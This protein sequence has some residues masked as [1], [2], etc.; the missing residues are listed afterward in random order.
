VLAEVKGMVH[1]L[2][3]AGIEVILDVVYNH[4]CEGDA[5]G[6]HLSW[7]G[8]DN[9]AYY[10]HDGSYPAT[11]ADVT[12]CGNT[13]DFR[14]PQVVRTAMDSVRYWADEVGV[15][16]FRFDLAVTL[17]RGPAGFDR[18]HPFLVALQTD[19]S[20]HG[21]KL[22]AEP[23]DVGPGGWHTGQFPPP[24]AEWNDRFRDA[25]RS[26]WLNDA[27]NAAHGYP[28]LGVR[29]LATRLA[30]SADLFGYSEPPLIRG[31]VAAVNY[32]TAHDGFTMADLVSYEHK[33]NQANGEGN[34]DGSS[35]NRAW[36][37]GFEGPV[38]HDSHGAVIL[39]LRR[40]SIRNL[41]GTLLLAA[42][43]PMITAGD[44]LGRT[45]LG[46]N[47]AFCQDS[48]VSWVDWDVSDWGEDLLDT[49][50]HLLALR[51]DH[52]ALRHDTFFL[53]RPW[54]PGTR[55]DLAW[56]DRDGAPFVDERWHDPH[57]RV[58][59]MLRSAPENDRRTPK[60]GAPESAVLL[61]INGSLDEADV[62]LADDR[63]TT[64]ELV[65]DSAWEHP[66][67]PETL[68]A[69]RDDLLVAA[70]DLTTLEPLSMRVYVSRS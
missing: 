35:D 59:Q 48:P 69:A 47:N 68:T 10:M 53:G 39:P 56:F 61:V 55:P 24:M 15:D 9:P 67:E 57:V 8:L 22:I 11:L 33:H 13:L 70:G 45:Q 62:V 14:R 40:R 54:G 36:N 64:W 66:D 3:Q 6:Q 32:V 31:P 43:T 46:N 27:A 18:L 65:W 26:F 52:P 51:R 25:V 38:A 44:E 34:R 37:H 21:L 2:H 29:E 28:G 49:T 12:G 7:R 30:G 19:P 4:T 50:R 42:G 20:M 1:L 16:G 41:M 23:W 63:P 17:G 5:S 58:L 60:R